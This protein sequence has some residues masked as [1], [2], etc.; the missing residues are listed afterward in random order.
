[1]RQKQTT[2]AKAGTGLDW[3]DLRVALALAQGGSVRGAARALGTSHS[4]VLRRLGALE[5]AVG[6]RLFER[7]DERYEPTNAGLDVIETAKELED[8]IVALER[9][10]EGRDLKLSGPLRVTLPDPL[11]PVLLPVFHRFSEQYPEI[12]T[13]L[14]TSQEYVD[15]AQREAD[16]ALRIAS[17]P[18]PDLVG[19]RAAEIACAIYGSQR[20][21]RGRATRNLEK[22]AWVGWP[23]GSNTTF[24]RWMREHV[25]GAHIALRV[26]SSCAM[27]EAI[28]A[29]AGI[30][31]MPCAFGDQ[32]PG[33][34]RVRLLPELSTPLWILTHRDLRA[35]ARVRA[36]RD[37]LWQ[38]ISDSRA[39]YAGQR[40]V[41]ASTL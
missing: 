15:L 41:K 9:R 1:M 19:R 21:L 13:L 5:A 28:D 10:V 31:I 4:T 8:A 34:Q 22:L 32:R 11:L 14:S 36:L 7:T 39:L 35:T 17:E 18:P 30:S 29:G 26:E 27:R 38:A 23:I 2:T 12:D 6:V 3:H 37:V 16:V 40:R 25:A 33:W 24:A 20:Y